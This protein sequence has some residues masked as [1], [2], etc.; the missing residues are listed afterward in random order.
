MSPTPTPA[1]TSEKRCRRGV[2]SGAEKDSP[3]E[4]ERDGGGA[5]RGVGAREVR[6]TAHKGL[7]PADPCAV[8]ADDD[9]SGGQDQCPRHLT[10]ALSIPGKSLM[11]LLML[12]LLPFSPLLHKEAYL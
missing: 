2:P 1:V 8:A 3:G 11:L 10:S 6:G 5:G 4:P 7:L 12:T 9:D